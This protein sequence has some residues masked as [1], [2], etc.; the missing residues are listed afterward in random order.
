MAPPMNRLL[1]TDDGF[2]VFAASDIN[3]IL[4]SNEKVKFA[5]STNIRKLVNPPLPVGYL[6]NVC[7][8]MYAQLSANDLLHLPI[9]KTAQLIKNSK[10]NMNDEYV[11][12]FID[13][14][15]INY[16]N[17][18]TTGKRILGYLEPVLSRNKP[19]LRL[20]SVGRLSGETTRSRQLSNG[21]R[22]AENHLKVEEFI[23][24]NCL[25]ELRFWGMYEFNKL[26]DLVKLWTKYFLIPHGVRASALQLIPVCEA[27]ASR[28]IFAIARIQYGELLVK[29]NANPVLV[30][31]SIPFIDCDL[32][33]S[34]VEISCK[35]DAMLPKNC[36]SNEFEPHICTGL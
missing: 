35:R 4:S 10:K 6:G 16:A 5:Y 32:L 15:D 31:A 13:F 19:M 9:W 8:P 22:R 28:Y 23:R 11:R 30:A 29:P 25:N 3:A 17:G 20:A 21:S 33:L 14:Q 18:I 34:K 12:S 2:S 27:V 24:K 26:I 1:E 36:S 7:V